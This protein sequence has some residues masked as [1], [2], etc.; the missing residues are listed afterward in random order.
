M[1]TIG[2]ISDTHIKVGGKR[3][4]P[5]IVFEAF[6]NADLIVH[7]G[8]VNSAQVLTDL[9][10]LAPVRAVYGNNCDWDV[11]HSVPQFQSFVVEECRIGLAHGDVGARKT[12]KPF[13]G[14]TGN[15]QAAANA[16]SWFEDDFRRGEPLDCLIFGHSHWPIVQWRE[17]HELPFWDTKKE[18]GLFEEASASTRA[19]SPSVLL[20]NP[21][22]VGKKRRAPHHTCG[23]LRI[24]GK[25]LETK[26]FAW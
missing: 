25:R 9:E 4:L 18:A 11:V 10:T 19:Q 1:T 23:V 8:D 21:G 14:A 5:P 3:Q 20:L 13:S 16:L 24:D 6:Q 7:A 22:S 26:L 15:N 17:N 2:V 12:V